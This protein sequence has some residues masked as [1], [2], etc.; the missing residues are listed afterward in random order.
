MAYWIHLMESGINLA[1]R[2]LEGFKIQGKKADGIRIQILRPHIKIRP[3]DNL[4]QQS[5]RLHQ[6][7]IGPM[8]RQRWVVAEIQADFRD[9]ARLQ[10]KRHCPL[11][12]V[13]E[14][15]PAKQW[16]KN[17]QHPA[18][19][20]RRIPNRWVTYSQQINCRRL[21][22]EIRT[23]RITSKTSGRS[24]IVRL[25]QSLA[26]SDRSMSMENPENSTL[27]IEYLLLHASPNVRAE[28]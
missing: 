6:L 17:G 24:M 8:T 11:S 23:P 22:P 9:L 3:K 13:E 2:C 5:L 12:Q 14:M 1:R 10:C 4:Q 15:V 16:T 26:T 27:Q 25:R 7:R 19:V 28:S 21:L 18:A 20:A